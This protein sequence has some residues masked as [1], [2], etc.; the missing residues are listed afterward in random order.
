[1]MD[2]SL[3]YGESFRSA[4]ADDDGNTNSRDS[5]VQVRLPMPV[6]LGQSPHIVVKIACGDQHTLALCKSGVVFA[7]GQARHGAL[8]LDFE[9]KVGKR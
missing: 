7:W 6:E 2:K 5:L 3:G 1:V 9:G 4:I 8:G